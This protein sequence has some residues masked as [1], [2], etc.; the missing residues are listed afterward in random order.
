M[1][2]WLT[3]TEKEKTGYQCHS[4]DPRMLAVINKWI[5]LKARTPQCDR[6]RRQIYAKLRDVCKIPIFHRAMQHFCRAAE[7]LQQPWRCPAWQD[8]T[9]S[10]YI[11][12]YFTHICYCSSPHCGVPAY[13]LI[14]MVSLPK[15]WKRI[16][17]NSWEYCWSAGNCLG[18]F[19]IAG[20]LKN[21]Y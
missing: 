15:N 5:S 12:L 6:G 9:L 19:T 7:L 11:A 16:L 13:T 17:L 2:T 18:G 3:W 21:S 4:S 20:L 1:L 8:E 14:R 10:S